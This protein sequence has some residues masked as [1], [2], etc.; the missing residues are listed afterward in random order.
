LWTYKYKKR[1]PLYNILDRVCEK[2][3][4]RMSIILASNQQ[5]VLSGC[6]CS[7]KKEEKKVLADVNI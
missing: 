4:R 6:N 7:E 5:T 1:V 3:W 2:R